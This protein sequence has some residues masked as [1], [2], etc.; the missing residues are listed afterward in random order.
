MLPEEIVRKILHQYSLHADATVCKS[1]L[2][3]KRA[4]ENRG[5]RAMQRHFRRYRLPYE[6]PLDESYTKN[7]ML[8]YYAAHY[9]SRYLLTYPEFVARKCTWISNEAREHV[10]NLPALDERCRRDALDFI[11][12]ADIDLE[13]IHYAGW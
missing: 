9:P 8:R 11:R 5:A 1:F 13:T 12:R 7:I 2:K 3:C 10:R 6:V 4:A